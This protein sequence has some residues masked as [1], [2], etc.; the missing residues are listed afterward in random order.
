[1]LF[2]VIVPLYLISVNIG[3]QANNE[4]QRSII[5]FTQQNL[6]FLVGNIEREFGNAIIRQH[7][8]VN[9]RDL[10][11]IIAHGDMPLSFEIARSNSDLKRQLQQIVL[12]SNYIERATIYIPNTMR[13]ISSEGVGRLTQRDIEFIEK[14]VGIVPYGPFMQVDDKVYVIFSPLI[15]IEEETLYI[16]SME[17]YLPLLEQ[18]LQ[19]FLES[20]HGNIILIGREGGIDVW[21]G[22]D[23]SLFGNLQYFVNFFDMETDVWESQQYLA[24]GHKSNMLNTTF[25]AY[26]Y[27]TQ[28]F[29]QITRHIN[30]LWILTAYLMMLIVIIVFIIKRMISAPLQKLTDGFAKVA[31]GDFNIELQY[32][33]N[34]EFG[35]AYKT[36]NEVA[37]Q[38]KQMIEQVYEQKIH[39]QSAELKQMQYQINPHFLYN[40]HYLIQI[41]SLSRDYEA[42]DRLSK[43]LG[44]FYRYITKGTMNEVTLSEEVANA[45]DYLEVQVMRFR[46]RVNVTFDEIPEGFENF[47]MPKLILQ[48]LIENAYSHG[49]EKIVKHG[50]LKVS[51]KS[52]NNFLIITV[53][54]NGNCVNEETVK[55]INERLTKLDKN[56][57][58]TG[59]INVHRRIRIRFGENSG[60]FVSRSEFGGFKAD[61][62]MEVKRG[63]TD[64]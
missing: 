16:I 20:E 50:V 55:S 39:A 3:M 32:S 40:S 35:Y 45:K 46:D 6:R 34:D 56:V 24:I 38:H 17:I 21:N 28:F 29:G 52:E 11:A 49:M 53:E 8:M 58:I 48:P 57:E 9:N 44:A 13:R 41:M 19:D 37:T 60:I 4:A 59:L 54:D 47:K 36:F 64:C 31:Q 14:A 12:E 22:I 30:W 23:D 43:H 26:F 27:R 7:E 25:V 15:S 5:D 51:I 2:F 33:G 1:M 63:C 62:K 10:Q 42:I 18:T 61:L